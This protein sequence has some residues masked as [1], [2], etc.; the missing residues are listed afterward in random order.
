MPSQQSVV[1]A[2]NPSG[3][4]PDLSPVATE[5]DAQICASAA[6]ETP[7]ATSC[8][9]TNRVKGFLGAGA[10]E[11]TSA[12][13]TLAPYSVAWVRGLTDDEL[14]PLGERALQDIADDILVL[15]EIRQRFRTKGSLHGYSGW[16]D[17]V[18]KNSRYSMRTIQNRLA[19]ANGKDAAKANLAPGNQYTRSAEPK[20]VAPTHTKAAAKDRSVKYDLAHERTLQPLTA[21][22]KK[23]WGKAV[24]LQHLL[25]TRGSTW[26]M[27][28]PHNTLTT[29]NLNPEKLGIRNPLS[30]TEIEFWSPKVL[31]DE[32]RSF[33]EPVY[34]LRLCNL[35]EGE[36]RIVAKALG[37]RTPE[38]EAAEFLNETPAMEHEVTPAKKPATGVTYTKDFLTQRD[39]DR[40][41]AELKTLPWKQHE[42][43]R[44][45]MREP[46]PQEYAW[47]GESPQPGAWTA[48]PHNHKAG[49]TF[50]PIPWT[51]AAMEIRQRVYEKTGVLFDSLNI[52]HYRDGSDHADWHVDKEDEGLWEFPIAS[53]SLGAERDFQTQ[54]YT[55]VNPRKRRKRH[56][57][58]PIFTQTLA[59]GS[60]AMMPAGS[61]GEFLH[62]LKPCSESKAEMTGE[63]INLTFRMMTPSTNDQQRA[64]DSGTAMEENKHGN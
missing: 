14:F 45:G 18:T 13:Q 58:G 5:V 30:E 37:C 20:P 7:S 63:R 54:R 59:H 26:G 44:Y 53:V 29:P 24:E 17:F 47:M 55:S 36:I 52:N 11:V 16:K 12:A 15:D 19:E 57:Q 61:Q 23:D 8:E 21:Q 51:P 50:E 64:D 27:V 48:S 34:H 49:E 38:P 35:T 31:F 62:H 10:E 28:V 9:A 46:A 60:L 40:L 25:A 4:S 39:A 43:Q 42:T 2:A 32:K 56:P 3:I 6:K 1:P 33:T 22:L 41:F